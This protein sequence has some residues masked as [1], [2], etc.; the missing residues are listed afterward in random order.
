MNLHTIRC[1]PAL[2]PIHLIGGTTMKHFKLMTIKLLTIPLLAGLLMLLNAC[3]NAAPPAE[4]TYTLTVSNL[5]PI[6]VTVSIDNVS[7]GI[8]AP[9]QA[10]DFTLTQGSHSVKAVPAG[11]GTPFEQSI[12]LIQN[13]VYTFTC[14]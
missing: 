13:D 1:I 7:R 3:G 11:G 12:T 14:G 5:C 6:S 8:F 2:E 4:K 10:R 9:A